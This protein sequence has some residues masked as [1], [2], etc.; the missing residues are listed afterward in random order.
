MTFL[1]LI[2]AGGVE[3]QFAEKF[4]GLFVDDADVFAV[5]EHDDAY[6]F[7]AAADSDVVHFAGVAEAD[8][9]GVV[10]FVGSYAGFAGDVLGVGFVFC[11][12]CVSLSNC[13]C[14]G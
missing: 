11:E 4:P 7:V 3:G 2:I 12:C 13:L 10:D 9:A 14:K 8:C 6:V 5:D 1:A